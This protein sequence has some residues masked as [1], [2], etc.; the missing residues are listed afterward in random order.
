MVGQLEEAVLGLQGPGER[1]LDVAGRASLS[2]KVSTRAEQSTG[3]NSCSARGLSRWMARATSSLPVPDSPVSRTVLSLGEDQLDLIEYPPHGG[4]LANDKPQAQA[5][6][7]CCFRCDP[8]VFLD[9]VIVGLLH[10][11]FQL[12]NWERL[13]QVV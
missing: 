8:A 12:V 4:T 11:R 5:I 7:C 1:A 10:H 3:T 2:S 9:E 6:G 13:H